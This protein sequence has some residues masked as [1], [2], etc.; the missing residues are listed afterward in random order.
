[1]RTLLVGVLLITS[2]F[3]ANEAHAW[4]RAGH[5]TIALIA[6]DQLE[7]ETRQRAIELLRQHERFTEHFEAKMPPAIEEGTEASQD[8]WIF[9]HACTWPDQVRR[10]SAQVTREDARQFNRPAWHYINLPHYLNDDEKEE[11]EGEI[12]VNLDTEVPSGDRARRKMNAIQA[13]KFSKIVLGSSSTREF[14]KAK[15]L[16]W[17]LHVGSDIFQ[18]LHSTALFTTQRFDTGDKGGNLI[19][20]RNQ[21]LHSVWDRMIAGNR[22]YNGV[23]RLA[24]ELQAD[25]ES[26]AAGEA[27]LTILDIEAWA[28]ESHEL[29]KEF[30]YSRPIL[31]FVE[32]R[33]PHG[34]GNLGSID[35][36]DEYFE[37]AGAV[38]KKRAIEAGY[39]LAKVLDGLLESE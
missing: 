20:I 29:A 25:A 19:E 31:E 28:D 14:K 8:R 6:Y 34:T 1:M 38:C 11:L 33:E 18:P 39:R 12:L 9:A 4:N 23:Q 2:L 32:S 13:F 24:A 22:G 7:P 30:S 17:F 35:P 27:A 5:M 15:Y 21:K 10:A 16:C 26:V 36:G 37:T 3:T